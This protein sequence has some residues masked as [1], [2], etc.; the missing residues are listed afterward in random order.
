M[1]YV[2]YWLHKHKFL[3]PLLG[4]PLAELALLIPDINLLTAVT[5]FLAQ[6]IFLV[7]G[8]YQLLRLLVFRRRRYFHRKRQREE[9]RDRR[10]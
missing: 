7:T 10:G 5:K 2:D 8:L 4:I 9:K 6:L 3:L 1:N